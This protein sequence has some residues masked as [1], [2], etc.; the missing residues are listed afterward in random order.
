MAL[1]SAST[2][3]YRACRCDA[4]VF[5]SFGGKDNTRRISSVVNPKAIDVVHKLCIEGVVEEG[6]F[7]LPLQPIWLSDVNQCQPNEAKEDGV[8][9]TGS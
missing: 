3:D 6:S 8:A 7:A 2:R 5:H 4:I 1:S 9:Y